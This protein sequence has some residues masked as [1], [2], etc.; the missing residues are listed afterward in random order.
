[1]ITICKTILQ[2]RSAR[3]DPGTDRGLASAGSADFSV[4]LAEDSALTVSVRTHE[5]STR[6]EV[7]R[8]GPP[9]HTEQTILRQVHPPPGRTHHIASL[10]TSGQPSRWSRHPLTTRSLK[11]SPG[12]QRPLPSGKPL[13]PLDP[14]VTA[15]PDIPQCVAQAGQHG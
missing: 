3:P 11:P 4:K 14:P 10:P 15:A 9:H 2:R 13:P 1:M 8:T 5:D 12:S 6:T 7:L